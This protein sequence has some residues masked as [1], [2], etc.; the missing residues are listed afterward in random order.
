MC[1]LNKE[2]KNNKS[3]VIHNLENK[4]IGNG[5]FMKKHLKKGQLKHNPSSVKE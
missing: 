4:S 5:V 1:I 3:N 2:I